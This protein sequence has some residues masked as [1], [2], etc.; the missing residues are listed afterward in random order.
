[1]LPLAAPAM[2]YFGIMMKGCRVGTAQHVAK[3]SGAIGQL[4]NPGSWP[5]YMFTSGA[6]NLCWTQPLLKFQQ[7]M[8]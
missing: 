2:T 3:D 6:V 7:C 1:M 5:L 8:L 4:F